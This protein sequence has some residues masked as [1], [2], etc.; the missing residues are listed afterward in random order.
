[1]TFQMLKAKKSDMALY[2]ARP[3]FRIQVEVRPSFLSPLKF[4]I[5]R[6]GTN[7]LNCSVFSHNFCETIS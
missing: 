4:H 3:P 2:P 5:R 1:M 7:S 6:T